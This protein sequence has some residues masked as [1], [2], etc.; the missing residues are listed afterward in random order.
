MEKRGVRFVAIDGVEPSLETL[1]SGAY[2]YS[3][4]LYFVLPDRKNALAEEF[5]VFLNSPAGHAALRETGN[6]PAAD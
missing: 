4:T 6:L 5:I 3:K 1:E 2:P